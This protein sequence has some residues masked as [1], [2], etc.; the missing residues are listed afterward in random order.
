MWLLELFFI[1]HIQNLGFFFC[2]YLQV[3]IDAADSIYLPSL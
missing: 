1:L 3:R 2:S